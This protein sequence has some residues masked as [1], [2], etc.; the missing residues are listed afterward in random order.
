MTPATNQTRQGHSTPPGLTELLCWSLNLDWEFFFVI[1]GIPVRERLR[2]I[3]SKYAFFLRDRC[4][5]G[6]HLPRQAKVLGVPYCYDDRFGLGSIQ[7]VFCASWKLKDVLNARPVVVDVGANLGQFNL[8]CRTYLGAERI[9]SIE[10][11]PACHSLLVKNAERQR[12]C[13]QALVTDNEVTTSLFVA[14]D[15]QLSSTV[16]ADNGE[17]YDKIE[18]QGT[19]LDHILD[20]AG[21][22]RI[23]LLKIDTEGSEIE[24]L[25]SAGKY[26][27]MAAVVF[28]E[29]SIF[30][31]NTGNLFAIGNLLESKGFRLHE[32]IFADSVHPTDTDGIFIRI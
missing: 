20:N 23:D 1:P 7:R 12:D 30:R 26:L 25:R 2:I 21:I 4:I 28:I 32:L 13:L 15:S 31:K 11:L 27:D 5:S 17:Y 16:Q 19:R 14:R 9:I 18:L 10:P 22:D 29:M 24:V 8:F 6:R 3:F